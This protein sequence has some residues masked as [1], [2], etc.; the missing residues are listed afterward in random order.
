VGNEV[1]VTMASLDNDELSVVHNEPTE[2]SKSQV[3][4]NLEQ[5]LRPKENV[6]ESKE[7]Q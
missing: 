5:K 4:V 1:T 3:N 7:Q 2:D 6:E